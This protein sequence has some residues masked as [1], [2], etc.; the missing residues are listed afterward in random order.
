[1][2]SPILCSVL[3]AAVGSAT[4]QYSLIRNYSGSNFFEGWDFFDGFDN[5]TNGDVNYL[6]QANAT[7]DNLVSVNSAGHAIIRVDNTTFV[8]FNFKRNSVKVITHD[9]FPIG[10]V[11]L[12]DALH[13]PFGCSVWPSF[14]T[15]GQNWPHGGEIDIMEGVNQATSDQMTLHANPG[16]MQAP[17]PV[18]LG[19]TSGADCS[20]GAN[21]SVGCTVLE[22]QPNSFGQ[23]FNDNG[24]GVWAAQFDV[25]GIFVWFWNRSA[26]PGDISSGSKTIDTSTWGTPSAAWPSSSCNI[27]EFFAPQ[28]LV[29]DITLCG[30]FAGQPNI[31]QETCGGPLGNSSVSICYI[32]NVINNGTAYNDAFFEIRAVQVFAASGSTPLVADG[33][34]GSSTILAPDTSTGSATGSGSPAGSTSGGA[35]GSGSTTE[36]NAAEG[37]GVQAGVRAGLAMWG[38]TVCAAFIWV[39]L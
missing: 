32:D 24:G 31:Y 12:F 19:K 28:Q 29:I 18:Q 20:A 26:L 6:S 25:S 5:T 34:S 38:A 10:S 1:M 17:N 9:F 2:R 15:M 35:G 21:S 36:Q 14:W 30:D 16:C 23:G 39:L 4:A 33:V 8:P 3:L 22:T 13:L 7:A 27:S 11:F 37:M